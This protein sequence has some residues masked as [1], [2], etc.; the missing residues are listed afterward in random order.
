[1]RKKCGLLILSRER[2]K[3]TAYKEKPSD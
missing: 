2:Q 3:M 1:M